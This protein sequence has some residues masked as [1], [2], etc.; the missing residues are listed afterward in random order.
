MFVYRARENLLSCQRSVSL[1]ALLVSP[2]KQPPFPRAVGTNLR[3]TYNRCWQLFES[4]DVPSALCVS[5]VLRKN[6]KSQQIPTK[7]MLSCLRALAN[8]ILSAGV[9]HPQ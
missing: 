4:S 6:Q 1:S 3:M 8:R 5:A 9:C 2:T 7:R